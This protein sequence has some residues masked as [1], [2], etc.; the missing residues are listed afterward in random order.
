MSIDD[1]SRALTR[2]TFLGHGLL[3]LGSLALGSLLDPRAFAAMPPPQRKRWTGVVNPPHFVPRARRVIHLYM[4]G[5]PSQFESFD[6]KPKLAAM[7]GQPMPES[8]TRGQPI[9][10]LQN[11]QLV[12]LAPQFGFEHYGASGQE[13]CTLF[14]HTAKVADSICIVRSAQTEQ[15]NHAP[16]HIFMNTGS[17]MPGRPSAG[18][19]VLYALGS[20]SENLPG[21]VVMVTSSPI[22]DQPLAPVI[23]Q[24]GFLSSQF[25]GVQFQPTGSPVH[26]LE[27]PAGVSADRQRDVIDAVGRINELALERELDPEIE[28]R[29]VQY[30]TAARMQTSVPELTDFSGEPKSVLDLYGVEPG[31]RTFAANCLLARRLAERGVRYVQVCHRGWDHHAGISSGMKLL[32]GDTDRGCAALVQRSPAA[33]HARRHAR[34]LGRRVW[35]DA[36]G[37]AR[38][39]RSPHPRLLDVAGGRRASAAGR[40]GAPPTTSATSPSTTPSTCTIYTRRCSISSAS[41]TSS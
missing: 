31:Q 29:I 21:Y 37:S 15:I 30:E 34:H 1:S 4:A 25:Q 28:A 16:A 8:F 5:G 12:C 40:P 10:Q 13:I 26:Y 17:L 7:N 23:W 9:A 35:T 6:Y 2:R 38:R 27:R 20:E 11:R 24:N 18:S 41:T 36:D 33:R 3:G 19:W 32:A 22:F 14:P 39:P